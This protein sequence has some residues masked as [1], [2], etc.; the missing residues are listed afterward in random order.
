MVAGAG[1]LVDDGGEIMW[2]MI[3]ASCDIRNGRKFKD[4]RS[5]GGGNAR[6]ADGRGSG[7]L[8][9]SFGCRHGKETTVI[10]RRIFNDL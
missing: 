1:P 6:I 9:W 10:H 2:W 7:V 4:L 8:D 5:Y 3:D